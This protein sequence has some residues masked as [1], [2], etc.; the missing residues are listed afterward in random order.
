MAATVAASE[1]RRVEETRELA[2]Q[3]AAEWIAAQPDAKLIREAGAIKCG[4]KGTVEVLELQK[5]YRQELAKITDGKVLA[6][7][8]ASLR[9]AASKVLDDG[10]CVVLRGFPLH[11][12]ASVAWR[13]LATVS[14]THLTLPTKA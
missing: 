11:E 5:E 10:G 8:C 12:D 13:C 2:A 4:K 14:Y 9:R 3:T 6:E 7:C 1:A